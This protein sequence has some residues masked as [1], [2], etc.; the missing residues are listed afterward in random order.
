MTR[1]LSSLF[2][3]L[4]LL[5]APL[6]G[7]DKPSFAGTWKLADP[8]TPDMFTPTVMT[9]VQDATTLTVTTTAQ[10]GE[11]K[12]SYKLDGSEGPSPMAFNGTTIDRM[13]KLAWEGRRLLLITTSKMEGQSF[14]FKSVWS[15]TAEG[16]LATETTFPDFQNGGKPTTLKATYKKSR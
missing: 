12:T 14:E 10:M 7:Q 4:I 2:A 16:A 11:F 3:C 13:T 5:A 15:L 9:V 8:A 6:A 1:A